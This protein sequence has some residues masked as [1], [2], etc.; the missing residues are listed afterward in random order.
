LATEDILD[1]AV[2][3]NYN[4][5][6]FN[7]I[8]AIK[9]WTPLNK[10]LTSQDTNLRSETLVQTSWVVIQSQDRDKDSLWTSH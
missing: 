9:I 4:N 7:R 8:P 2:N 10:D 1:L 6:Q 3:N 5:M